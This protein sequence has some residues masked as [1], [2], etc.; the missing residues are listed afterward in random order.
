MRTN[1]LLCALA[2]AGLL[3]VGCVFP[4]QAESTSFSL[5]PVEPS[6]SVTVPDSITLSRDP[7]T[8]KAVTIQA[9]SVAHLPE[10]KYISVTVQSI[11]D[12]AGQS[13]ETLYL[14]DS[15]GEGKA[16]MVLT[17]SEGIALDP[18]SSLLGLEL[19]GL[20]E[21]SSVTYHVALESEADDQIDYQPTVLTYGIGLA[22]FQ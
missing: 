5:E 18:S 3:A 11:R 22:D 12:G 14:C 6:Y 19:A 16:P 8:S 17:T 4:A 9:S 7:G 21:S 15:Q 1:R 13:V 2:A 10:G 20:T